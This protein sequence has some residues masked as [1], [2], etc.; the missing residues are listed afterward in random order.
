MGTP[1]GQTTFKC[2]SVLSLAEG[3]LYILTDFDFF[4]FFLKDF[5]PFLTL[6]LL[7]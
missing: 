2:G 4:T 6:F 1:L 3:W 5:S 7:F